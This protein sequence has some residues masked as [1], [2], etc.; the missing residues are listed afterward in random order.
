[1][2]RDTDADWRHLA[3]T[4]PYY[5][6]VALDQFHAENMD[7]ARLDA[8]Y[9]SGHHDLGDA[10]RHIRQRDPDFRPRHALDFGCGVGRLALA[11]ASHATEV[12]GLDVAP[13][14]LAKARNAADHRG[15]RNVRFTHA[16][17]DERFD[18]I[19]SLIVLQHI[20]PARGMPILADLFA[21]LD[22]GGF[23]SVQ[24]T[25]FRTAVAT[26]IRT[27]SHWFFDGERMQM[28]VEN[29]QDNTG[30]M[31][32]YDYDLN[33]VLALMVSNNVDPYALS[34]TDHGGNHGAWIFGYRDPGRY[35]VARGRRYGPNGEHSF[36]RFLGT[37][38]GRMEDWGIW[39]LGREAIIELQLPAGER[40][41]VR[42][43]GRAFVLAGQHPRL[44]VSVEANGSPAAYQSA[45]ADN[46]EL[47]ITIPPGLVDERGVLRL[48]L[49]VDQP[50]SPR[51]LGVADDDRILGFGMRA[52]TILG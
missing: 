42:L 2:A 39:T 12:V 5:A 50:R 18:W 10:L 29:D 46:P 36:A 8:F 33:R 24:L 43:E 25:L 38:W 47:S 6:V 3:E 21:R 44:S 16:L 13:G 35:R 31:R 22:V 40:G 4:D 9:A 41:A 15:V 45:T 32:M 20:P 30:V 23:C 1:M 37:G 49:E 51:Q 48:K 28:M 19:N 11:L 7:S 27:G 26:S 14:M 52:L 17:T 34:M